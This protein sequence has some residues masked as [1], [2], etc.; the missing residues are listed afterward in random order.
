VKAVVDRLEKT[1]AMPYS[2]V[3]SAPASAEA[4]M[5]FLSC[6]G[7]ASMGERLRDEG[8]HVV[9][10]YDDLYKQALAYRQVMLLLRRPPGRE[11]F[12]G[13]VFNLHSRLLERAAKLSKAKGGGSLTALPVVETQEGDVSAYIPT[14]VISITDGQ[15]FLESSLFNAGQRPAVNAGISVSRVGGSAQI[16]AMKKIAGGLRIQLAQFRELA[17]FAQFGSDLDKGTQQALTRG[18]RM[19]E[20]LKQPEFAPVPVEEQVVILYAGSSGLLDTVPLDRVSE[21]EKQYLAFVRSSHADL[22]NTLRTEKKWTEAVQKQCDEIGGKFKDQ[23][24]GP[25]AAKAEKAPVT[26]GGSKGGEAKPAA[27]KA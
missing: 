24:L 13:D 10:A 19:T 16:P 8:R 22:F 4:S 23:F 12:P 11:A 14:N 1:G 5:Q 26:Q 9:I 20:I 17:A 18:Q 3:V 27:R 2:I 6:Y 7:G 21:F 25:L 15:I